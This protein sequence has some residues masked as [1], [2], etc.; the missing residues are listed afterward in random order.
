[1]YIL[2]F[3]IYIYIYIYY[4]VGSGVFPVTYFPMMNPYQQRR[5]RR[6][7]LEKARRGFFLLVFVYTHGK[8]S[9]WLTPRS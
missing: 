8:K 2:I 6:N 4:F 7:K 1:M 9:S 5:S 3:D